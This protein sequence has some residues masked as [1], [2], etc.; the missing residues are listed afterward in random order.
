MTTP[1]GPTTPAS[2]ATSHLDPG[3]VL[4]RA[5]EIYRTEAATLLTAAVLVFALEA[6]LA[7]LLGFIGAA[8]GWI[9][10]YFFTGMV[11]RLVQDVQD[12]SRDTSL[13]DLFSSVTPVLLPLIAV[14]ILAAIGIGIGLILLII[15][16]LFLLTIWAVVVPVT[17]VEKPG[18]F[19]AFGRSQRLVSGNGWQVFGLGLIV[20]VL[21]LGI[22]ILVGAIA[23]SSSD[24][25]RAIVQWIVNIIIAP[26][27]ALIIAVLYYALRGVHGEGAGPSTTPSAGGIGI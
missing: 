23:G 25:V 18:I 8:I 7:L 16:G 26:I 6:V 14:S 2:P 3:A 15:P 27:G 1:T 24:V 21:S 19:A 13:G 22:G 20:L 9:I 10:S 11:V 12:G 4:S 5:V 17:V